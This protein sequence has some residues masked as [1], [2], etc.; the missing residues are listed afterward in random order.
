MGAMAGRAEDLVTALKA[1]QARVR[2]AQSSLQ[3]G[4]VGAVSGEPG[5]WWVTVSEGRLT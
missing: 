2:V 4:A 5:D 3:C 1:S